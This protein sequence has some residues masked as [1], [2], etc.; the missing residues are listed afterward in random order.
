L[1]L[2]HALIKAEHVMVFAATPLCF[3]AWYSSTALSHPPA[4]PHVL[5]RVVNAGSARSELRVLKHSGHLP[6]R[7]HGHSL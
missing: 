3:I 7:A 2:P 6:W 5:M 1:L 4:R